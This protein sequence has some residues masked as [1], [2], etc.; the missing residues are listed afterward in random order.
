L[1]GEEE[2]ADERE[3]LNDRRNDQNGFGCE[4]RLRLQFRDLNARREQKMKKVRREKEIR[5]RRGGRSKTTIH[6]SV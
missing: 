6:L 1:E 3:R 4:G 5:K 2:E